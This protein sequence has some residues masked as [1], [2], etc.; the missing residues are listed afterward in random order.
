MAI[1]G[2]TKRPHSVKAEFDPEFSS[3]AHGGVVLA[4]RVLRRLGIRRSIDEH[5]PPRR[6]T[7]VFSTVDVVYALLGGL[8]VGGKGF[9][10]CECL[11]E[12]LQCE[13]IFG[14]EQGAPSAPTV[15]RSMCDLAGLEERKI[16]EAYEKSGRVLPALDI[17]GEERH[18]TQLR[19][20]VAEEPESATPENLAALNDFGASVARRCAQSVPQKIVAQHGWNIVFGDATDL[21]VDGNCFDAARVRRDGAKILRWQT[22]MLGPVMVGQELGLGTRDEGLCMPAVLDR[23]RQTIV[24]IVG[25]AGR[26]LALLDAAYFEK[27]IVEPLTAWPQWDFI[28]CANQQCATLTRIADQQPECVWDNT[29]ADEQRGWI[30]SHVCVFRHLP[31]EWNE[32]VNIVA[33]RWR[34]DDDLP[35]VWRHS[36]VATSIEPSDLPSQL[37][38]KHGYC[39]AIWMLYGTK[40]GRENHYKTALRDLGL[41]HPPSGRLGANQVFYAVAMAAANIAMVMRYRVIK[42]PKEQGIQLWRLR[43]RYFQIAGY[44]VR[45]G[46]TLTVR[47]SGVC[48]DALRQTLWRSAFAEAGRL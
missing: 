18:E 33:R 22:V 44:L 16:D 3:T 19:R 15:Y 2:D 40:Q 38:K 27:Q 41:H 25:P 10:A 30:E 28:V 8:V 42:D 34:K 7:S 31:K 17:F 24:E 32:P 5:L 29:G 4:E 39:Q 46:R 6:A 43:Q 26:M 21:E 9:Q 23:A 13:A 48:V 47:L 45:S 35:G 37:L 20:I 36:F 12:D 1:Q 11:R 14:L